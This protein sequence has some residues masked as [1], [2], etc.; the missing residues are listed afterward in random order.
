MRLLWYRLRRYDALPVV[1]A[2][3]LFDF[4]SV[5][6]FKFESIII[7][8]QQGRDTSFRDTSVMDVS[9]KGRMITEK[10]FVDAPLC[11]AGR[12]QRKNMGGL[13]Q[14]TCTKKCTCAIYIFSPLWLVQRG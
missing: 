9:C 14:L 5:Y 11:H 6:V 1:P 2:A 12:D 13:Q 8:N 10:T 3:H 4:L 7:Y